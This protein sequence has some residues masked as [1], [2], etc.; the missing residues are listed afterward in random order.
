MNAILSFGPICRPNVYECEI[1]A[2]RPLCSFS[3][4]PS[5]E[6]PVPFDELFSRAWRFSGLWVDARS[7]E[8]LPWHRDLHVLD[9]HILG[10]DDPH[11]PRKPALTETTTKIR[12]YPVARVSQNIAKT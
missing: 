2:E 1:S 4:G 6:G 5:T 3:P 8:P 11:R 10:R 7:T 12:A 9:I